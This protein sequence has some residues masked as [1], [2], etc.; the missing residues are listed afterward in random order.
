[1]HKKLG[2][3]FCEQ[4]DDKNRQDI[5]IKVL[6]TTVSC[7]LKMCEIITVMFDAYVQWYTK[8]MLKAIA[9]QKTSRIVKNSRKQICLGLRSAKF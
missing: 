4:N 2:P 9:A 6:C 3:P 8:S 5:L 7:P 1:M